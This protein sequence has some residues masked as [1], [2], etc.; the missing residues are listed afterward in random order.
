ML[1]RLAKRFEVHFVARGATTDPPDLCRSFEGRT[2]LPLPRPWRDVADALAQLRLA[3]D[4][5]PARVLT[6][7][8][9][10]YENAF[11][12]PHDGSSPDKRAAMGQAKPTAKQKVLEE[13]E[14]RTLAD[15]GHLLAVSPKVAREFAARRPGLP[16]TV[17]PPPLPGIVNAPQAAPL[18]PMHVVWCGQDARRKGADVA[19]AWFRALRARVPDAHLSMWGRDL[20]HMQRHLGASHRALIDEG[21]VLRGWDG[22]FADELGGAHLL[23]LPTRYDPCALVGVEAAAQGVP[24]LTT[25]DNGFAELVPPPLCDTAALDDAEAAA[26]KALDLVAQRADAAP[27]E[28]AAKASEVRQAFSLDAHVEGLIRVLTTKPD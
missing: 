27:G 24:V 7:R 21:V 1:P 13:L 25:T 9:T 16:T 26:A 3:K 12:Q 11:W 5:G 14:E 2:R 15:C 18:G 19:L 6:L 17:L 10:P 23:M 22:Q 8:R 4:L 20:K 28:W